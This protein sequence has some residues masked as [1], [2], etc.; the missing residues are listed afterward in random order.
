M[1]NVKIVPTAVVKAVATSATSVTVTLP[2]QSAFYDTTPATATPLSKVNCDNAIL[3]AQPSGSSKLADT[4]ACALTAQSTTLT[5]TFDGSKAFADGKTVVGR[6]VYSSLCS[7][8][9]VVDSRAEQALIV[10]PAGDQVTVVNT[11]DGHT[12]RVYDST[13]AKSIPYGAGAAVKIRPTIAS[14]VATSTSVVVA[15]LLVPGSLYPAAS[16][17][18]PATSLSANDCAT[19]IE[20]TPPL[21]SG[22]TFTCS[23]SSD[24]TK[25]TV[26]FSGAAFSSGVYVRVTHAPRVAAAE[27]LVL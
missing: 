27:L 13:A 26:T 18:N 2:V 9:C 4:N 20:F 25:L 24:G 22:T 23:I 1:T 15:T 3:V 17:N 21:A 19:I 5:L 12:L 8:E 16:P 10:I 6:A 14:A 7:D 11:A